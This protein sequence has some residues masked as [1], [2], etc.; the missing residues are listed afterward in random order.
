MGT[1]VIDV[2][3]T[4]TG[5]LH[6]E[7]LLGVDGVRYSVDSFEHMPILAV[8]VTGNACPTAKAWDSELIKLQRDYLGHG[9][10]LLVV[11]P[12]NQ[13]LSPQDMFDRMVSRAADAGFNFPYVKDEGAVF[14]KR[15]GAFVTPQVF[16]FDAD[17]KLRYTGR[18]ADS[19]R[20]AAVMRYDL[21]MAI[22]D[23]V[24][25]R[26]VEVPQTDPFGCALVL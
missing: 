17:R 20:P 4:Q 9:L 14:A 22:E 3:P 15:L 10:Q 26:E 21:K 7:E 19:R 25:G 5:P 24:A 23:L 6:F 2:A 11:N 13:Y 1:N 8:I 12:N 18:I 16:L